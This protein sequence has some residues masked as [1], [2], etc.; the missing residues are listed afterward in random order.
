MPPRSSFVPYCRS[1][2][3]STLNSFSKIQNPSTV[4]AGSEYTS[5]HPMSFHAWNSWTSAILSALMYDTGH[6][7]V[8]TF[9]LAQITRGGPG[10]S[11]N[12]PHR[13]T[14]SRPLLLESPHFHAARFAN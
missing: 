9:F 8:D 7:S 12:H 2:S 6:V 14:V 4:R 11:A 10:S 1:F 13:R 5:A 3:I